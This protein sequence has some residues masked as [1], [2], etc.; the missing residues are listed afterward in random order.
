[1]SYLLSC[2]PLPPTLPSPHLLAAIKKLYWSELLLLKMWVNILSPHG[3]VSTE[4]W[5]RC[6]SFSKCLLLTLRFLGRPWLS[7]EFMIRSELSSPSHTIH[8]H[9][10]KRDGFPRKKVNEAAEMAAN[11]NSASK[12]FMCA[13]LNHRVRL[14]MIKISFQDQKAAE[15]I[16]AE[17]I[18]FS[19]RI[20][21]QSNSFIICIQSSK[22]RIEFISN[23]PPTSTHI[24]AAL[25]SNISERTRKTVCRA[26]G[27]M[28]V[29][30]QRLAL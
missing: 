17:F 18:S 6:D 14:Q 16:P 24:I 30:S 3:R 20:T 8:R 9:A 5:A 4:W 10:R 23:P 21:A 27:W 19:C 26:G 22:A 1:M 29:S 13:Q 11:L 15:R 7:I 25:C 2:S 28:R 12:S